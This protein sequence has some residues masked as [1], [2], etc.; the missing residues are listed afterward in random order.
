MLFLRKILQSKKLERFRRFL[1]IKT[2][3]YLKLKKFTA[4]TSS[5]LRIAKILKHQKIDTVIDIGA[6][7]GQFAESL[8]DFGY[9]GKIISFE[10]GE[11]AYSEILKRS[12]NHSKWIIAEK[13]ALGNKDG[14]IDLYISE[15]SVFSSVLE[16]K[17]AHSLQKKDSRIIRTESVNMHRLDSI[18]HNY[19]DKNDRTILLKIDTQGYE[20]EVLEGA[21]ELFKKIVGIKIEIP[22]F[23][24]YDKTGFTFYEI[25]ELMRINNFQ[26]Y[27]FEVEGVDLKKGH[28]NTIDGLFFKDS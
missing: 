15:N 21:A 28:I 8:F 4:S 6:N 19:L 26:P 18:I 22:V 9:N 12:K 11:K 14:S 24:I 10:P 7:T 13:C 3:I 27:N 23:P 20:K 16:I 5:E 2:G 25:L 1:G 17:N